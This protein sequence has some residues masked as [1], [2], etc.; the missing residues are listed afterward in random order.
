MVGGE[1]LLRMADSNP[2]AGGLRLAGWLFFAVAYICGGYFGLLASIDSLKA[3]KIDIDLLMVLAAIG[4]ASVGAPFEGALLLFLFSLSNVLQDYALNRTRSAIHSLARLRPDTAVLLDSEESNQGRVVQASEVE[5]G[6]LVQVK[7]GHRVPLDGVVIRGSSTV[8]QSSITG[9]SMPVTK[10]A[11]DDALAGTINQ[12]G[13]FVVRVTKRSGESTIAKVIELVENAREQQAHTERFLERFE[14]YYAIGVIAAT[15]AAG[16]IPSLLFG[17]D[18]GPTVYRAITLMVAASPCALIISTPASILSAIGNGARRGILFKGG[19]HVEQAAGIQA[20]AF[21]KTGTLTEGRP[22]VQEVVAMGDLGTNDIVAAAA[23]LESRSEHVIA[24]A[25]LEYAEQNQVAWSQPDDFKSRSGLG[26]QGSVNGQQLLLG[27][28]S[29]LQENKENV[30]DFTS[31]QAEIERLEQEIKTVIVLARANGS[32]WQ[33]LGLITLIDRLRQGVPAMVK[34][35]RQAGIKHVVMLTGDNRTAA[36][37]IA[38]EAGIDEV[39]PELLPEHKLDAVRRIEEKFG[40]TAM[41]GDG[42]NDAPALAGAR[43]GIAMGAAGTDV[44]LE[45]ADIVLL[46]D[47]ITRIPYLIALSRATRRTLITNIS[48]ALGLIA[49]MI[50]GIYLIDL[51]LPL[52]VIGHEGGT[53]L[54]SLNGIRLL[55]FKHKTGNFHLS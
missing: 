36:R 20:I 52:A 42:V 33:V 24:R 37:A 47:D 16:T 10:Q 2:S 19:V 18:W 15:I 11:G 41:I 39:F 9:E 5:P 25:V 26:V 29:M 54:V 30:T 32:Q 45:T 44:A 21:D 17:A 23:A 14:Q 3:R 1:I 6:M 31:V 27:S 12:E 49:L 55:L 35:L 28:P 22:V 40:P 7:P 50:T 48:I 34:Q 46:S 43:L 53:V 4:A 8:D 13:E 38:N 51:P